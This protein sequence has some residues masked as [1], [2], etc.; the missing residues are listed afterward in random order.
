MKINKNSTSKPVPFIDQIKN[1][2]LSKTPV[3]TDF[4]YVLK[5]RSQVKPLHSLDSGKRTGVLPSGHLAIRQP[6]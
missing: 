4:G 5:N 2:I 1:K 3:F 6:G